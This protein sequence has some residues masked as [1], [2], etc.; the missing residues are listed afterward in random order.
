MSSLRTG[1]VVLVLAAVSTRIVIGG[2]PVGGCDGKHRLAVTPEQSCLEFTRVEEQTC[3]NADERVD[4]KCAETLTVDAKYVTSAG[5]PGAGSS[6]AGAGVT[7]VE[8]PPGGWAYVGPGSDASTSGRTEIAAKLGAAS[9]TFT[10]EQFA[11][12]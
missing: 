4:N 1:V 8:V 2:A 6:K 10:L 5:T 12:E 7:T 9:I 3:G 11:R